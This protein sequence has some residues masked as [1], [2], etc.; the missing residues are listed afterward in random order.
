MVGLI[1]WAKGDAS[2]WLTAGL[3]ERLLRLGVL[4][5]GGLVVYIIT[6]ALLGLKPRMFQLQASRGHD[7]AL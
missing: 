6:L 7:R 5:G 3:L 1:W 2:V 4:V